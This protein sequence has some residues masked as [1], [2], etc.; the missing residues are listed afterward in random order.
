MD[1]NTKMKMHRVTKPIID[2]IAATPLRY[3]TALD[4]WA[5]IG[6]NDSYNNMCELI[7]SVMHSV[8]DIELLTDMKRLIE[9][10]NV[11]KALYDECKHLIEDDETKPIHLVPITN[12]HDGTGSTWTE[13]QIEYRSEIADKTMELNDSGRFKDAVKYFRQQTNCG[14]L[15]SAQVVQNRLYMAQY[16]QTGNITPPKC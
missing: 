10:S 1:F 12:E 9:Y 14:M 3:R 7:K 5:L 8:D 16:V 11:V 6:I 13:T 4:A 15:N 2:K